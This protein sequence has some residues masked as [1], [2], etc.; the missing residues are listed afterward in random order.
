MTVRVRRCGRGTRQSHYSLSL[1]RRI[2]G[3]I[4]V[5]LHPDQKLLGVSL[6]L[7][8]NLFTSRTRGRCGRAQVVS[9]LP[10]TR[11]ARACTSPRS[12]FCSI[13]YFISSSS[14]SNSPGQV[15]SKNRDRPRGGLGWVVY[16]HSNSIWAIATAAPA[17]NLLLRK[18]TGHHFFFFFNLMRC[19][20]VSA[21]SSAAASA[22][23]FAFAVSSGFRPL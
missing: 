19:C 22:R 18:S 6:N 10:H 2:S 12:K 11:Q 1:L 7:L 13:W 9:R 3:R 16:M 5:E 23:P 17:T 20:L 4:C 15:A 8:Y 14:N 21:W